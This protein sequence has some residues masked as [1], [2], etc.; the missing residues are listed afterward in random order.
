MDGFTFVDIFETKG[1]E[2]ILVLVFLV[3]FIFFMRALTKETP[4]SGDSEQ[5]E[6]DEQAG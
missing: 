2:Y 4:R 5:G 1:I 3:V 6:G